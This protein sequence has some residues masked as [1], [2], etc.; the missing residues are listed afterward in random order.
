MVNILVSSERIIEFLIKILC[1][2]LV[3]S[4]PASGMVIWYIS[5]T[6][7]DSKDLGALISLENM[8]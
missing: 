6:Q 3:S 7:L 1:L 2:I 8:M 4:S 5:H